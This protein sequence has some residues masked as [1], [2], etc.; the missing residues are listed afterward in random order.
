MAYRLI[1][2]SDAFVRILGP[3]KVVEPGIDYQALSRYNPIIISLNV[4]SSEVLNVTVGFP[5]GIA[6]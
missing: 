1:E 5:G 3:G 4:T 2:K 6:S